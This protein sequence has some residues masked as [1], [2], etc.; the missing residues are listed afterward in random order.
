MTDM[1]V[2][3]YDSVGVE[4]GEGPLSYPVGRSM[5]T[6]DRWRQGEPLFVEIFPAFAGLEAPSTWSAIVNVTF[7]ARRASELEVTGV[8]TTRALSMNPG[9][10]VPIQFTPLTVNWELADGFQHLL[11]V[12]VTP[13]GGAPA[14]RRQ[15][16]G[17]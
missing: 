10:S 14:V 13:A 6:L 2:T 8:D 11:E 1:G 12:E 3:V 4:I 5:F 17:R 16:I 7:M 15:T 9:E